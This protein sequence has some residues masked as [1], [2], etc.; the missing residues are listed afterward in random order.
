MH[1]RRCVPFVCISLFL[2]IRVSV[3]FVVCI[4]INYS[5]RLKIASPQS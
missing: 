2:H 4:K 3:M 1:I 5:G